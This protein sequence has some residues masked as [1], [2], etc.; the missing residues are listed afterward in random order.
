[1][2]ENNNDFN[3]DNENRT[4]PQMSVDEYFRIKYSQL[5]GWLLFIVVGFIVAI[6]VIFLDS[7][8][9][10]VD[11][12]GGFYSIDVAVG[13]MA[14]ILTYVSISFF[15]VF[16]FCLIDKRESFLYY[17]QIGLLVLAGANFFRGVLVYITFNTV[18]YDTLKTMQIPLILLLLF[19]WKGSLFLP[20][21]IMLYLCKSARVR[22]Y[23]GGTEHLTEAVYAFGAKP[24]TATPT[25]NSPERTHNERKQ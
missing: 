13:G 14:S 17:Y 4:P 6:P 24:F 10:I 21:I 1:M 22:T 5:G 12:G 3:N 15:S 19:A 2:N 16:V 25:T 7:L 23:M 8:G 18:A 20:V 11:I 9:G